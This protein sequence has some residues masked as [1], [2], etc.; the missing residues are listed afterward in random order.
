MKKKILFL[1]LLANIANALET[2]IKTVFNATWGAEGLS[3]PAAQIVEI[4]TVAL[5]RDNEFDETEPVIPS[6]TTKK[7]N[8]VLTPVG[9]KPAPI[10]VSNQDEVDFEFSK[11]YVSR[12]VQFDKT[13]LDAK[14]KIKDI[15]TE[16]GAVVKARPHRLDQ[17][18]N[19]FDVNRMYVYANVDTDKVK[20]NSNVYI[21]GYEN[22]TPGLNKYSEEGYRDPKSKLQLD[23]EGRVVPIE[24]IVSPD[25]FFKFNGSL[26]SVKDYSL[27]PG[28]RVK[29][30]DNK[31]H[32]LN[33]SLAYE[34]AK[35]TD[36]DALAY[37]AKDIKTFAMGNRNVEYFKN[38][39]LGRGII[40]INYNID[41]RIKD[42]NGNKAYRVIGLRD[43][44]KGHLSGMNGSIRTV[45]EPTGA[46]FGQTLVEKLMSETVQIVKDNIQD[47]ELIFNTIRNRRIDLNLIGQVFKPTLKTDIEDIINNK[48]GKRDA[49]INT[50]IDK[51]MDEVNIDIKE[52]LSDFHGLHLI[53]REYREYLS[54]ALPPIPYEDSAAN[55]KKR[56]TEKPLPD[57]IIVPKETVK[58]E[59]TFVKPNGTQLKVDLTKYGSTAVD[60]GIFVVPHDAQ[61]AIFNTEF[62]NSIVRFADIAK[63]A[64]QKFSFNALINYIKDGDAIIK[65]L[66]KGG[67]LDD[68]FFNP[69]NL[70]TFDMFAGLQFNKS[71]H[72]YRQ[73]GYQKEIIGALGDNIEAL[74]DDKKFKVKNNENGYTHG[75]RF[76]L[77]YEYKKKPIYVTFD[78]YGHFNSGSKEIVKT[79]K[80]VL[81]RNVDFYERYIYNKYPKRNFSDWISSDSKIK[82][83]ESMLSINNDIEFGYKGKQFNFK[84]EVDTNFRTIKFSSEGEE[85]LNYAMFKYVGPAGLVK[86]GRT[87]EKLDFIS[88]VNIDY[89]KFTINPKLNVSYTFKPNKY[90]DIKPSFIFEGLYTRNI[91]NK[92]EYARYSKNEA[93]TDK[94]KLK[95]IEIEV[96]DR[97]ANNNLKKYGNADLSASPYFNKLKH[98]ASVDLSK[99]SKYAINDVESSFI[100]KKV[101]GGVSNW[102]KPVSEFMFGLD[103]NFNPIKNLSLG[104]HFS[105]PLVF[106]GKNIH[107][108]YIR[109]GL[110]A[111]LRF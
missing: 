11:R 83:N 45:G 18:F 62:K 98:G 103:L 33:V 75:Y 110:S 27:S 86:N 49:I 43:P 66:I 16:L 107:A 60:K 71:E 30:I 15:G 104:Y 34:I 109:N 85:T 6:F 50:V 68:L 32:S 9:D 23:I 40:D 76:N 5:P 79:D 102:D 63:R 38:W 59:P 96:F 35:N 7:P 67:K 70:E 4:L 25:I 39:E 69:S 14:V 37:A 97:D 1:F 108:F 29:A 105:A 100:K 24:Y 41:G 17:G 26:D 36:K 111:T 57:I 93:N 95:E 8:V 22:G 88:K 51:V 81:A 74:S 106:Y 13:L 19:I 61:N 77:E 78:S 55:I 99:I 21:T 56:Q 54:N 3:T 80:T 89:N 20:L 58:K 84:G 42:A 44:K 31:E 90:F 48:N 2:E 72:E 53:P 91:Y 12:Q 94:A 101:S 65:D 28:I 10:I 52:P 47:D 73:A 82:E 87:V 46:L 92:I 64:E